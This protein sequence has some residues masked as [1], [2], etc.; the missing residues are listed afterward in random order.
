MSAILP[1][2]FLFRYTL[3]VRYCPSLPGEEG[4]PPA[5]TLFSAVDP[6]SHPGALDDAPEFAELKLVWNE[7]GLGFSLRV[8][9]KKQRPRCHPAHPTD[10]DGLQLFLDTR[11]TQSIH[12]ASQFCHHFCLLP[13]GG[14]R[15]K[16]NPV[17]LQIPV[18]RARADAPLVDSSVLRLAAQKHD[19]GYVLAGHL[20]AEALHGFDPESNRRLGFF[21]CVRDAE[22]GTQTLSVGEEFPYASDPSLWSTLELVRQTD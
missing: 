20:P 18:A 8:R 16:Q 14:G 13:A 10:S 19:D 11:N 17:G 9:G 22:L 4:A 6:L 12:R 2:A 3:P 7:N 1:A 15:S 21:Y 5:E